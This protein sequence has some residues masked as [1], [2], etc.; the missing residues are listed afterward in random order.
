MNITCDGLS[1][2]AESARN[3]RLSEGSL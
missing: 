3:E 1:D 2:T